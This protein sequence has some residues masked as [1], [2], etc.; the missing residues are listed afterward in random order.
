MNLLKRLFSIE[1][2]RFGIVGVIATAVHYGIYYILLNVINPNL[3]FTIGYLL[4]F[5][6][7][8]WLSAKFT[9]KAEA[10]AKRGVGFALSHLVNYGLQ[11]IV[12]NVSLKLGVPETL[13]PVPVY[14]ICIPVNFLLVRFV[15]KK[16]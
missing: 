4:S 3:A 5:F 9:F 8:F 6:M 10:T 15:F 2:I 1:F 11:M 13:A 7:N 14:L 12:L 16:I